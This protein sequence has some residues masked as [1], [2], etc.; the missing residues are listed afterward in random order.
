MN[1]NNIFNQAGNG[2]IGMSGPQGFTAN[3]SFMRDSRAVDSGMAFL[4]GELEKQDPNLYE[5]LTSVTWPRDIVAETGG[6]FVDFTSNYFVN[7]ST[8]SPNMNG[9][10]AGQSNA[11]PVMQ[12]DISKDVFKCF[13]WA[14]ILKVP[15]VDQQKM[16]Q[17]GR[18]LEQILDD[19]IKLNYNKTIDSMVYTGFDAL[20][21]YGLVNNPNVTT[22]AVANNAAGSSKLWKNKTPAEILADVNEILTAGWAA[23]EYDLSGMP[24]DILIDPVNY[25]YISTELIST[26]GTVSILEYLLKNNIAANQGLK[27]SILPSRWCK[28]AGVGSTQRMVAY[29]ND[30]KRTRYDLPV[31]LMR[32]LTQPL[33]TEMS[34]LT[35][36]VAQLGQTKF[37]YLQPPQYRDGI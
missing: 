31:P 16:Q 21:I 28:G 8:S 34:Y 25:G 17:I 5:P 22:A 14:H 9:L 4:V 33:V 12:A 30:R 3:P 24:I 2:M 26:A 35:A 15:F 36:Y 23:S 32:A 11:I 1:F 37:L 29:V 20:G 18:S 7:Y 13:T 10:I 27:L 19:G 6:G